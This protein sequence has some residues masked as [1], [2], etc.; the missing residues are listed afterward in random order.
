MFFEDKNFRLI[1][2]P[3]LIIFSIALALITE[4][5]Q[6]TLYQIMNFFNNNDN[7]LSLLFFSII[8]SGIILISTGFLI[9]SATIFL[10][11]LISLIIDNHCETC[12]TDAI[13]KQLYKILKLNRYFKLQKSKSKCNKKKQKFNAVTMFIHH[14]LK[15][16][17]EG[18]FSW[19]SRRWNIFM[20]TCN[21]IIALIF[22][23][24][25]GSYIMKVHLSCIWWWFFSIS[26]IV[27]LCCAKFIY[28]QH[29][30]VFSYIVINFKLIENNK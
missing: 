26:I 25:F 28:F 23:W 22:S 5:C 11:H 3:I 14:F 4:N 15:K 7:K 30:K 21:S 20:I 19:L 29:W 8:G 18:L 9:S 27:L 16:K 10:L 13:Y 17:S 24:I 6:S 1:V 12:I 2:P